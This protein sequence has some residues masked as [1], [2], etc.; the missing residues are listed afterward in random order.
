MFDV[1]FLLVLEVFDL[2][3]IIMVLRLISWLMMS[4]VKF[5]RVVVV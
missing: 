4:G 5:K 3:F 2:V 1:G